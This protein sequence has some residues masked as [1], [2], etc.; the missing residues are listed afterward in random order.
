MSHIYNSDLSAFE[1]YHLAMDAELE[2]KTSHSSRYESGPALPALGHA[3]SGACGSAISTILTYPLALIVTRLQVKQRKS[4]NADT[5][6]KALKAAEEGKAGQAVEDPEEYKSLKDAFLKI[7]DGGKD[8][9]ALYSGIAAEEMKTVLDSFLFFLSYTFIR[10]SRLKSHGPNARRLPTHEELLV[11]MAA[12]AFGRLWTT[13]LGNVVTR[14]QTADVKSATASL[15]TK[16]LMHKIYEE[17]GIMG[18]WSGY[19]ATLVLTLNPALT[20][21]LHES[22]LRVFVARDK[23]ANPGGRTT[24]AIA[25][26]SKSLASA[27]TY[28]FSLAKSRMQV[29]RKESAASGEKAKAS[30]GVFAMVARI[31]QNEGLLALYSG[32]EFEMSKGFLSHGLTMLLKERIHKV[33]IQTYYMVLKL[34]RRYPASD[35]TGMMAAGARLVQNT[36]TGKRA[37]RPPSKKLEEALESIQELYEHAREETMDIIDEYVPRDDD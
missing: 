32:L 7:T 6:E 13:P 20:F 15:T 14:K 29:D 2:G 16:E 28:P 27:I 11:G 5:G 17:R 25:A 24:F 35:A 4:K 30:S 23:R 19:G 37:G 26:V 22:L 10:N 36:V 3:L 18:F 12:G 21:L 31:L 33:V 1:L 9:S 8:I 34:L